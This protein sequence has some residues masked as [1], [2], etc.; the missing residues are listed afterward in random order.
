[1]TTPTEERVL[2][3]D[4]IVQ[5]KD[6][7]KAG[8][9]SCKQWR[10][11]TK[12]QGSEEDAEVELLSYL[13]ESD[14]ERKGLWHNIREKKKREGKN[15]KPAKPAIKIDQTQRLGKSSR[16]KEKIKSSIQRRFQAPCYV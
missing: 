13:D 10:S 2:E 9:W 5:K 6:K 8:Y 12:V 14:G 16:A 15:Y 3:L 4:T 11:S 1:M 7:T